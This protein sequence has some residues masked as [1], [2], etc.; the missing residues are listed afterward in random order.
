MKKLYIIHL[1]PFKLS[2]GGDI[3][4]SSAKINTILTFPWT[5]LEAVDMPCAS[6]EDFDDIDPFA[7]TMVDIMADPDTAVVIDFYSNDSHL[8]SG[9]AREDARD[10]VIMVPLRWVNIGNIYKHNP[11]EAVIRTTE[12]LETGYD[13]A[14]CGY[15]SAV[16][17][18][19]VSGG[20]H[21]DG[22][23]VHEA[24]IDIK[25]MCATLNELLKL[26]LE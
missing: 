24:C 8:T 13:L 9:R 17:G 11:T 21:A 12:A 7:L 23:W 5:G 4:D 20:K 3:Y 6:Q 2:L 1:P 18:F 26:R 16:N 25:D 14:I 19:V 10:D 22:S 15:S